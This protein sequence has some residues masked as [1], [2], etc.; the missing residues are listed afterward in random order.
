MLKRGLLVGGILL[1]VLVLVGCGVS[2]EDYDAMVAERDSAQAELHSAQVEIAALNAELAEKEAQL[3][4]IEQ[5]LGPSGTKMEIAGLLCDYNYMEW[6]AAT[7]D[8]ST[9]ELVDWATTDF[10]DN[11]TVYVT[12]VGDSQLTKL[13]DDAFI[14]FSPLQVYSIALQNYDD[15][16]N[17]VGELL[18]DDF[19]ALWTVLLAD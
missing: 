14:W 3:S 8:I 1:L 11:M 6:K 2:Q 19:T 4:D 16:Y 15:L 5:I 13:W 12:E 17:Y 9:D 7:A 10:K 18:I